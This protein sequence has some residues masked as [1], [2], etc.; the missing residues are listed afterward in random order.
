MLGCYAILHQ[1][2]LSHEQ[3]NQGFKSFLGVKRRLEV[4]VE[5][6]GLVL[7]DDFAHHPTAVHETL[8]AVRQKYPEHKIIAIF[9]PRSA[10][11]SGKVFTANYIQALSS[12]DQVILAPVGRN[13]AEDQK[14]P[15]KKIALEINNLG[16]KASAHDNYEDF[17]QEFLHVEPNS[18]LLF[19]SN[20]DLGG[21]MQTIENLIAQRKNF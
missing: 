6:N 20:G 10:T 12:A 8:K 21:H 18:V 1:Y 2:G 5:K 15:T 13:L 16:K 14:L 3:I 4:R 9:E 19:M 17:K 7:I 11:S